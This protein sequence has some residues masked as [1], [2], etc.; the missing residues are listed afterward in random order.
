MKF[1]LNINRLAGCLPRALNKDSVL[2]ELIHV[3]LW[4]PYREPSSCSDVYF[5]TIVDD[6]SRAV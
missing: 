1:V 5:L 4:G 2:F 6:I 3:D